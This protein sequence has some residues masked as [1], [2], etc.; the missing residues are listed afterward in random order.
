MAAP[1]MSSLPTMSMSPMVSPRDDE[2]KSIL[3]ISFT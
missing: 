2:A 3:A 1:L